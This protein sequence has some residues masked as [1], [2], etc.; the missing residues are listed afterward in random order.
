MP[1]T[2]PG[3]AL[4]AQSGGPTAVINSSASG[5]IQEAQRLGIRRILGASNGILGILQE[6]LFDV[7]AETCETIAGLRWTP[8]AA[9]G[10]CRYK[11]GN[12]E[13]DGAK[14]QRAIEVLRAHEIRYFFYI[15]GNDSMDTAAKI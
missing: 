6:D 14:Y 12:L 11:L 2:L 10:S 8:A 7:S 13:K 3:N 1:S 4:V 15:G 5:V 9:I